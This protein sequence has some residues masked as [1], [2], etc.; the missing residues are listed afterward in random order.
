M[1]AVV[2]ALDEASTALVHVLW[3]GIADE[4]GLRQPYAHPTPHF[5]YHVAEQYDWMRLRD[6]LW[7]ASRDHGPFRVHAG[8]IG[9]FTGR[10]LVVHIPVVRNPALNA[11]QRE[12]WRDLDGVG[13][14]PVQHFHPELWIPHITLAHHGLTEEVLPD[15]VRWLAAR[16]FTWEIRVDH[17][18][19]IETHGLE[20]A[21][22]HRFSLAALSAAAPRERST[23]GP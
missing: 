14:N 4:F 20:Q 19:V 3:E 1:Q 15:L 9:L 23:P 18:G 10:K 8:G 16:T 21:L 17:V 12:L 6:A 22:A 11:I 2:S 7:H 5:T 13:K